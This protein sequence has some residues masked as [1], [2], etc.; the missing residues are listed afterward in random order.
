[1]CNF[2][3]LAVAS[4]FYFGV[5]I[6]TQWSFSA[7]STDLLHLLP[8]STL[9]IGSQTHF[10]MWDSTTPSIN[11]CVTLGSVRVV[12]PAVLVTISWRSAHS[13]T[14]SHAKS[15]DFKH[16]RQR[17]VPCF[18]SKP[19]EMIFVRDNRHIFPDF[20]DIWNTAVTRAPPGACDFEMSSQS[21]L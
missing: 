20:Q 5:L 4:L 6:R 10:S 21:G 2:W 16:V 9:T 19:F 17:R 11:A 7:F 1:M 3:I 15:P 12:R 14:C 18:S 13:T 8:Y